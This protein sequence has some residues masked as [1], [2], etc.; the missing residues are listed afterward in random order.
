MYKTGDIGRY[1]P[2]GNL[3]YVGR[4]DHQVK[5]RGFRIELGE[6]ETRLA[7]KPLVEKAAV[8]AIGEGSRRKL[9]AYVVA[10]PNDQLIHTLRSHLATCLPD[11]MVPSAIV[12]LDSFR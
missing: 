12:R 11:Y 5:I 1:L 4:D 3:I 7:D 6:I 2:D 10:Q 8:L 9:V